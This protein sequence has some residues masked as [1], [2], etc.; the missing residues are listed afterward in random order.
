MHLDS[1]V[2]E[3]KISSSTYSNLKQSLITV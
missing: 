3:H 2:F 1:V